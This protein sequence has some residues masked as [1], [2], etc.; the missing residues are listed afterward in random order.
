MWREMGE[1]PLRKLISESSN[2][3]P[4]FFYTPTCG[5]CK[6]AR[7]IL[8][9]ILHSQPDITVVSCNLNLIPRLA[10]EWQI[11]RN[12]ALLMVGQNGVVKRRYDFFP[13]EDL[14]EWM[15]NHKA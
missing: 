4:V 7:R 12:P 3:V 11:E 15:A 1:K 13:G 9:A 2:P 8:D 6:M 10:I 5:N 14:A